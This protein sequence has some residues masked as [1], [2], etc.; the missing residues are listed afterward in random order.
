MLPSPACS[1][2]SEYVAW[3]HRRCM[4]SLP[5]PIASLLLLI[6]A[7][8]LPVLML[9]L[10]VQVERKEEADSMGRSGEWG[11][12]A[13]SSQDWG[14]ALWENIGCLGNR[15]WSLGCGNQK[16]AG[17]KS[18]IQKKKSSQGWRWCGGRW[19]DVS[20]AVSK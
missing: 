20:R 9:T 16:E 18:S 5:W 12:G 3:V 19:R 2:H 13:L 10:H 15:S 14:G 6:F 8:A 17:N 1:S 11:V 4:S 7:V